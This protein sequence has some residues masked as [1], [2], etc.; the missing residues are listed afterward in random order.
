MVAKAKPAAGPREPR[1]RTGRTGA[2]GL[3]GPAGPS[4]NGDL[5][6]SSQVSEIVKELQTQ[7][8]RIAQ[9]QAQLDRLATGQSPERRDRRSTDRVE[10]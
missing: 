8:T 3:Q 6:L 5:R 10:H 7:L 4:A 2:R 9:I 1:G